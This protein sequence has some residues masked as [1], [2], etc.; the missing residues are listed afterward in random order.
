VL[1]GSIPFTLT[2]LFLLFIPLC[3]CWMTCYHCQQPVLYVHQ[4]ERRGS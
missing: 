3:G 1:A 2:S 4:A